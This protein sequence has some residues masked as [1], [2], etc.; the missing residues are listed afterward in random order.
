MA[1]TCQFVVP[2]VAGAVALIF[3]G[4]AVGQLTSGSYSVTHTYLFTTPAG[5]PPV[6]FFNG[7]AQAGAFEPAVGWDT[8][9]IAVNGWGIGQGAFN[10]QARAGTDRPTAGFFDAGATAGIAANV[11]N[12]GGGLWSASMQSYGSAHASRFPNRA[13]ATSSLSTQISTPVWANGQLRWTPR[14]IDAVGGGVS[15]RGFSFRRTDPINLAVFDALGQQLENERW[16]DFE[17]LTNDP[18]EWGPGGMSMGA[19][20]DVRLTM[21]RAASAFLPGQAGG[22]ADWEVV[23]GLV[24]RSELTGVFQGILPPV[25]TDL[26]AGFNFSQLSTDAPWLTFNFDFSGIGPGSSLRWGLGGDGSVFIP[27]IPAPGAAGM[28]A[29][30]GIIAARRRRH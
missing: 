14:I 23:N 20:P 15:T 3:A 2:A 17:A 18:M 7:S 11:L 4:T 5:L 16:F 6:A 8:R 27:T 25:G 24:T 30:A 10:Q 28:L 9:G 22:A 21:S 29:L 26:S 1:S 12:W 13:F 19:H